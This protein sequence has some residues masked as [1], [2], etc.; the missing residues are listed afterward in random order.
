MIAFCLVYND[1]ICSAVYPAG[2]TFT[3]Y[4]VCQ[5]GTLIFALHAMHDE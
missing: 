5:K 1:M 2:P 4:A 3:V